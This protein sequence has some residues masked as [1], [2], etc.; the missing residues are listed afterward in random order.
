MPVAVDALDA[1]RAFPLLAVISNS[2][3]SS[4]TFPDELE[5]ARGGVAEWGG[6]AATGSGPLAA[7]CSNLDLKLFT[8]S[9]IW[10]GSISRD[11]VKSRAERPPDHHIIITLI[12]MSATTSLSHLLS[13]SPA[14]PH[15]HKY[16]QKTRRCGQIQRVDI[17]LLPKHA[18]RRRTTT[19]AAAAATPRRTG[20]VCIQIPPK[21]NREQVSRSDGGKGQVAPVFGKVGLL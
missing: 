5:A 9:S 11:V 2:S 16:S 1:R 7:S 6:V 4:F 20:F 10:K 8:E 19:A 15:T 17:T 21:D 14:R 13:I 3:S 18:P 12:L